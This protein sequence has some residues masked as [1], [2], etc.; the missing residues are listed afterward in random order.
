MSKNSDNSNIIS[1]NK[2]KS[3]K[4][5]TKNNKASIII[6]AQD[7]C[8]DLSINNCDP[9][10]VTN[11]IASCA[12]NYFS[13]PDINGGQELF[14]HFLKSNF[15][16]SCMIDCG[17]TIDDLVTAISQQAINSF[18]QDNGLEQQLKDKLDD[19]QKLIINMNNNHEQISKKVF[20]QDEQPTKKRTRRTRKKSSAEQVINNN[21]NIQSDI[22]NNNEINLSADNVK[23]NAKNNIKNNTDNISSDE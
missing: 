13:S 14:A 18:I 6:E 9:F 7:D 15:V 17:L 10:D 16:V 5:Q 21:V 2:I 3:S 1:F 19:D 22:I 8:L 20:D 23:N 12:N 4:K 11:M